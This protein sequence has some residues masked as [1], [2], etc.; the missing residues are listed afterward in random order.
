[1]I[2]NIPT[3]N[4]AYSLI[5]HEESQNAHLNMAVQMSHTKSH[6][7]ER[8]SSA[9]V[10]VALMRHG[11]NLMQKSVMQPHYEEGETS[12]SSMGNIFSRNS[13]NI[14]T[15]KNNLQCDFCHL[16]GHRKEQCYKLIGYPPDFKFTRD[17][18]R[19]QNAYRN[20]N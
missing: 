17:R 7:K 13:N 15:R 5:I 18:E 6:Y 3:V 9:L 2:P 12:G 16:R 10:A 1:M 14:R 8:E 20:G 11:H 4:Q 19:E